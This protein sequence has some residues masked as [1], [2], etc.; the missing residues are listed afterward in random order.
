M[1]TKV[2]AILSQKGGAG[3][4]TIAVHLAVAALRHGFR[5]AVYD[6]DPQQSATFWSQ[7]RGGEVSMVTSVE[8]KRI[9]EAVA[10]ARLRGVDLLIVDTAPNAGPDAVDVAMA[11]DQILIPVRPSAFD[12]VAAKR[13]VEIANNVRVSASFV[14]SACPP[15]IQEVGMSR[16]ALTKAMGLPVMVSEIGLRQS[17]AR[18]IQTGR[19]VVEFEP[20]G[21]AALEIEQLLDEIL[22]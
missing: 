1:D 15:R 6:T 11:A 2:L 8:A 21:K 10:N 17:F 20:K 22:A 4:T 7:T 5:V 16:S 12:L 18:A 13:T 14:L 19:A 9:T 3:K